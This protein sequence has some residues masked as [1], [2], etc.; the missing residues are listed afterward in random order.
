[1]IR[2][3]LICSA[4]HEFES[5]FRSSADFDRQKAAKL[6]ACPLCGS[7]EVERALMAP[8]V[9]SGKPSAGEAKQGD[10]GEPD[11]KET[12]A[13][14]DAPQP[15]VL[16]DPARAALIEAMAEIRKKVM[17]TADYV[18]DQFAEEA[19]RIHYGEVERHG[20]YGEASNDE[21]RALID[22]GIDVHALPVL[23][24]DRN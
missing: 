3:A 21:A 2:Y 16:A 13:A 8:S 18:G 7:I 20:I 19:R 9:V 12:P 10:A 24:G 6:L 11:V 5:W 14:A 15:M 17:E 4:E 23:P 22:E 1:M